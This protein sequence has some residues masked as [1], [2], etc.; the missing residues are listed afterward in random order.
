VITDVISLSRH[1]QKSSQHVQAGATGDGAICSKNRKIVPYHG[2]DPNSK[3]SARLQSL[4]PIMA[5]GSIHEFVYQSIFL[6]AFL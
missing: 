4:S 6:L 3:N 2:D 1:A 5:S